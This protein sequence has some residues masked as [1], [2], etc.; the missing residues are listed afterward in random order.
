MP[1]ILISA[2]QK[3]S[4]GLGGCQKGVEFAKWLK[5]LSIASSFWMVCY[6]QLYKIGV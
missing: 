3:M 6:G 4:L 1:C 2:M 5:F